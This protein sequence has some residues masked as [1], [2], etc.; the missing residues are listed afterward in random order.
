MPLIAQVQLG[1]AAA[2]A[3]ADKAA[4]VKAAA[5]KAAADKA[6]AAKAAAD[7]AA[8]DKAAADKAAAVK[9][10]ADK[11]A[12]DNAAAA[13]AAAD[14]EAAAKAL[15]DAE[16]ARA[17]AQAAAALRAKEGQQAQAAAAR[18]AQVKH[19]RG[20]CAPCCKPLAPCCCVSA[21]GEAIFGC[22]PT[23]RYYF[24]PACLHMALCPQLGCDP[25]G[26]DVN[27]DCIVPLV[28]NLLICCFQVSSDTSFSGLPCLW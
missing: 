28:S 22:V 8:A 4:A 5:D 3:P 19:F 9:A 2:K 26:G 27:M 25:R 15:Q 1:E 12:A 6:A 14:K 18:E 24:L 20:P 21:D 16:D 17:S 11:V 7:K 10:A 13:M 23:D